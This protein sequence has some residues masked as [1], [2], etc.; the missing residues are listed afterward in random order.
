MRNIYESLF[1]KYKEIKEG[2]MVYNKYPLN[3][4]D[5]FHLFTVIKIKDNCVDLKSRDG[6]VLEDVVLDALTRS[7]ILN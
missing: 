4:F 5:V 7:K 3:E 2:D 6:K 1:K